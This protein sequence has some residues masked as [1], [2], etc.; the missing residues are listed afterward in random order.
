MQVSVEAGGPLEK[1]LK[2]TVPA[3][4]VESVV[5]GHLKRLT[6]TVR[7]PG[8]RP[9]KVPMRLIEQRYGNQVLIDAYD[10]IVNRTYPRAIAEKGLHP[11]GQP[12][13]DIESSGRGKDFSYSASI[14]IYPE[15]EPH[16]SE[17]EIEKPVATI[18]DQDVDRT[19]Q[20]LREQRRSYE[21][22]DRAAEMGDQLLIN[23]KGFVNDEPFAGGEAQGFPLVLGSGRTIAG[24]EEGLVGAVSGEDRTVEVTFPEDYPSADIAGKSARFEISVQS[25]LAPKLPEIDDA[26]CRALGVED[27]SVATLRKEVKENLEYEAERASKVKVKNQVMDMLVAA[28]TIDLPRQLVDVEKQRIQDGMARQQ[29]LSPEQIAEQAEPVEA[30]ARRRVT[31]GLVMTELARRNHL[32]ADHS[33]VQQELERMAGLYEDPEQLMSWYRGN[34]ERMAEVEAMVLEDKVVDL[35][36][37]RA[38]VQEKP[39]SFDALIGRNQR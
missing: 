29:G 18:T 9:G 16:V 35:V 36:L 22:V 10:E 32:E 13:I 3:A 7:M 4:E 8:F 17:A 31:L 14:E 27:G 21:A 28:N 2:I 26:F 24:F 38:K 20:A 19:I 39:V 23:F 30:M 33:S 5:S 6:S 37:T 1:R 25:V 12:S 15:F 34:P 11:V